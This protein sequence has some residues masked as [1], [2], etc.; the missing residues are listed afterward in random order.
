MKASTALVPTDP[1][2]SITIHDTFSSHGGVVR[3][4][5]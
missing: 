2:R 1:R 3:E 5:S 4:P